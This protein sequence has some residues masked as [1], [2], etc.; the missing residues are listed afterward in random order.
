MWIWLALAAAVALAAV[1][2][3]LGGLYGLL[4]LPAVLLVVAL[5]AGWRS[6]RE[7]GGIVKPPS[8]DR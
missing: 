3:R 7:P 4:V 6:R 2:V 8:A 5:L 1:G